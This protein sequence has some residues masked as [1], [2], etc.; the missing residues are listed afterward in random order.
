MP[1]LEGHA[2]VLLVRNV[3]EALDWWRD[4]LG[5]EVEPY[6][7]NPGHY[8][9]ARRDDVYVHVAARF[10]PGP[11]SAT[12]PPDMFDLY[13][14]VDDVDALHEEVRERGVAEILHGPVEQEYGLYEF[15]V[16]D[17]NG[18]IVAFG[19]PV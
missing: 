8:G 3:A 4:A 5:F 17:P 11:N 19:R 15:R 1:R 10:E 2:T 14:Y 6:A 7:D 18:Y 12:F 9:S 13:V 16:R